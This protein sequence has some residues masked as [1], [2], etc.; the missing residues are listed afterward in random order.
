MCPRISIPTLP[1]PT[2]LAF[3]IH[4]ARD[5]P[6]D[7][8]FFFSL[9]LSTT[10]V[11]AYIRTRLHRRPDGRR[12]GIISVFP[13]TR[14]TRNVGQ[15]SPPAAAAAAASTSASASA[16]ALS[17]AFS[18]RLDSAPSRIDNSRL[19]RSH[20]L[21][22]LP[23]FFRGSFFPFSFFSLSLS[24]SLILSYLILSRFEAKNIETRGLSEN[25]RLAECQRAARCHLL[26]REWGGE[27]GGY[28]GSKLAIII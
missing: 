17:F 2:R 8:T 23:P 3:S 18:T 24:F 5:H 7:P 9:S 10:Y 27:G 4:T 20:P 21:S 28:T 15:R 16:S 22:L 25:S 13:Q 1:Y 14:L 11:R 26:L 19:N 12:P 6:R